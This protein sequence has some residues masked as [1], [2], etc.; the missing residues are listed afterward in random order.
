MKKL[1]LILLLVVANASNLSAQKILTRT[2]KI[3][4]FSSTPIENIEAI[5][6]DVSCVLNTT[7]GDLIFVVPIKSFRF[8]K[9]LMQ[10]HFNE[11]YMESDKFPKSEFKGKLLDIA[12]INFSK[13]GNYSVKTSGQLTI[14]GVTKEVQVGGS[15]VIRNGK[16]NLSATFKVKTADY[17]IKIPAIT[18]GKIAKEIEV[19]VNCLMNSL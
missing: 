19:T 14:H 6:N 9:Q 11:N 10:E 1:C 17:N 7:S 16:P 15:L 12:S 3:T 13:D 2:G 8:E 5:N 4:F 18:A